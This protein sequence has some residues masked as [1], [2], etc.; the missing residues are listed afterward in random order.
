MVDQAF[1]DQALS[2]TIEQLRNSTSVEE[3]GE[4]LYPGERSLRTRKENLQN[5]I[6][7]DEKVWQN[8]RKLAGEL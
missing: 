4:I 5:G 6:P 8:V 7:V 1:I 3:A 2:E